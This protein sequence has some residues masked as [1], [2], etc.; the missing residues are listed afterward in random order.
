MAND[1]RTP[2]CD[3]AQQASIIVYFD[4]TNL[5]GWCMT[6]CLPQ[7]DNQKVDADWDSLY[8]RFDDYDEDVSTGYVFSMSMRVPPELHNKLDSGPSARG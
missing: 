8:A 4:A 1:P 5:H 7:R 6:K 3:P 2:E